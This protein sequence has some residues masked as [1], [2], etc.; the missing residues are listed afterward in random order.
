MVRDG[1]AR[2]LLQET[3]ATEQALADADRAVLVLLPVPHA[4]K[5]AP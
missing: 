3:G 5:Q 4:G 2:D 1:A